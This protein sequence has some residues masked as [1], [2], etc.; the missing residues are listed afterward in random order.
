MKATSAATLDQTVPREHPGTPVILNCFL[1]LKF[2]LIFLKNYLNI[3]FV[4]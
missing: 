2:I 3:R 4:D 1:F